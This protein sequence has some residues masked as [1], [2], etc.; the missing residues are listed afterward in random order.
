MIFMFF[1]TSRSVLLIGAAICPFKLKSRITTCSWHGYVPRHAACR[2]THEADPK[3][4][5]DRHA[6]DADEIFRWRI[7][8]FCPKTTAAE[9]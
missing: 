4:Q 6:N 7:V 8:R 3:Q 9:R 5:C 2:V 1:F